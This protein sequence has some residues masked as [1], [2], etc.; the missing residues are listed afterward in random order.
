M[1]EAREAFQQMLKMAILFGGMAIFYIWL[2]GKF[3]KKMKN[4]RR[5]RK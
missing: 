3:L 2:E 1:E 5:G 4:K